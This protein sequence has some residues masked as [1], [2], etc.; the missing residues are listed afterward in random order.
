MSVGLA[1]LDRDG[2]PTIHTFRLSEPTVTGK[3]ED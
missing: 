3:K 2:W 1:A